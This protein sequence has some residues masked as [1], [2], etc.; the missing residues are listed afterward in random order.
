[1]IAIKMRLNLITQSIGKLE[2]FGKWTAVAALLIMMLLTVV[3]VCARYFLKSAIVGA[4][5]VT[6]LLLVT[7]IFLGLSYTS[8]TGGNVKVELIISMLS[9]RMQERLVVV[10]TLFNAI[11]VSILSWRLFANSLSAFAFNEKTI[12]L[13][14]PIGPIVLIAAIG[15]TMLTV[16][17]AVKFAVSAMELFKKKQDEPAPSPK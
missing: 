3:D 6:E 8:S 13:T 11:V 2:A 9:Q 12:I 5:D 7:V 10:T 16:E 14:I 15:C 4:Q 1:M 17:L